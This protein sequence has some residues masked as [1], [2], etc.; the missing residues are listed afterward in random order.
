MRNEN[1]FAILLLKFYNKPG[2]KMNLKEVVNFELVGELTFTAVEEKF[3][4]FDRQ[5]L[6]WVLQYQETI[7]KLR[8]DLQIYA[9][10]YFRA[11][12]RELNLMF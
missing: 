8:F 12:K 4:K 7:P 11:K 2:D 5:E 10:V 9:L 3:G 6:L 1:H